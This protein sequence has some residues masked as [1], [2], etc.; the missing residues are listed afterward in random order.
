MKA[1]Y[2]PWLVA[3]TALLIAQVALTGYMTFGRGRESTIAIG[4]SAMDGQ[5]SLRSIPDLPKTNIAFVQT[6]HDFG[7]IKDDKKQY[8]TF[9]FVNKG[10]EPLL[11]LSAEGSCG[12]TVP[13]WPREPVAPGK[14]GKIEVSFDPNGKTGEHTKIVTITSNTDPQTTILTIKATIVKSN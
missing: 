12:C 13:T 5:P 7:V 2:T 3:I 4:H 1:P 6:A 9:D 14:T 10:K 11:I 8:A